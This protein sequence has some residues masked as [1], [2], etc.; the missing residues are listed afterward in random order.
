MLISMTNFKDFG[1]IFSL[2]MKM[3]RDE[4]QTAFRV[5]DGISLL[6]GVIIWNS[7]MGMELL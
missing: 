1:L 7:L 6:R 5:V 4:F 3:T 2:I